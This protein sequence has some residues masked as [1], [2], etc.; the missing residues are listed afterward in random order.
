MGCDMVR[1]LFRA[2]GWQL[3]FGAM[4]AVVAMYYLGELAARPVGATVVVDNVSEVGF[5]PGNFTV[6]ESD[7]VG[8]AEV[9]ISAAPAEGAEVVVNYVTV[10]G[11]AIS[12]EAGDYNDTTGV[13]TF[14]HSSPLTQTFEVEIHDDLTLNE[15]DETINL[16]LMLLTPATA[17]IGRNVAIMVITDNDVIPPAQ[18]IYAQ[19][20]LAPGLSPPE[21][22]RP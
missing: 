12:G 5:P 8:I 14:T 16:I 3:L 19:P 22:Q 13:I 6:N 17:T 18:T 21:L 11:T 4:A 15:P 9:A 2:R 7:G 20:V 1:G 10:P